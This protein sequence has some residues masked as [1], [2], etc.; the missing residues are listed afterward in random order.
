MLSKIF[1]LFLVR[2]RDKIAV[3]LFYWFLLLAY[4]EYRCYTIQYKS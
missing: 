3:I 1:I 2:C 4:I